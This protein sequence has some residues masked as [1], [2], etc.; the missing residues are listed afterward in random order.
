MDLPI[1]TLF[2]AS[3]RTNRLEKNI[4]F[5]ICLLSKPESF[6]LTAGD[7]F[8]FWF[9]SRFW[10]YISKYAVFRFVEMVKE[11]YLVLLELLIDAIYRSS[12]QQETPMI[13]LIA[14]SYIPSFYKV[15]IKKVSVLYRY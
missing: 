9:N 7:R 11:G 15:Y 13:I 12:S 6:L 1:N 8:G 4:L 3:D 14:S 5:T 10:F 2:G